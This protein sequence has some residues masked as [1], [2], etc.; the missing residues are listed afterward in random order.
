L[1]STYAALRHSELFGNVLCQSGNFW[2]SPG[3]AGDA[4]SG[5]TGWL[6]KEYIKKPRLPVRF[7]MDVGTFEVDSSGAGGGI[8]ESNRHMRDVL[9][10]KGY[11]V[12][13]HEFAS[14]HDYLTWRGTLGDGLIR[15][16][17]SLR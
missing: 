12:D 3:D 2:W 15:L 13:Y 7:W 4:A 9:L 11:A 6:A 8:L 5:D 10:A 1:A 16:I 14:G 17:G